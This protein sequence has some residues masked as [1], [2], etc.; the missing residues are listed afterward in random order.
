[1][2]HAKGVYLVGNDGATSSK[3]VHSHEEPGNDGAHHPG[4]HMFLKLEMMGQH[5]SSRRI[6]WK[7]WK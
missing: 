3:Q 2:V 6:G 7:S 5:H 1:M 4:V